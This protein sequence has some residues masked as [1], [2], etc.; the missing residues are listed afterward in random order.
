MLKMGEKRK[1][2]RKKDA[3]F[4]KLVSLIHTVTDSVTDEKLRGVAWG[5]LV[6]HEVEYQQEDH[7]EPKKDHGCHEQF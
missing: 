4:R 2:K 1:R 6:L 3:G 7:T 5:A